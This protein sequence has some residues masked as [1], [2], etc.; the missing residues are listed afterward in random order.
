MDTFEFVLL[1]FWFEAPVLLR[2]VICDVFL[3]W[4][5]SELTAV[6]VIAPYPC[7]AHM[8]AFP[9]SKDAGSMVDSTNQISLE[10]TKKKG[11]ETNREVL[12]IKK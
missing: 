3:C 12:T 10:I 4:L 11:Q 7:Q 1:M 5:S 2:E 6:A 8:S 9:L